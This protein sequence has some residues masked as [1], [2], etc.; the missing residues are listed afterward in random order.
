V[1][2]EQ[3]A[4]SSATAAK[5]TFA[6]GLMLGLVLVLQLFAASSS[7]HHWLH[8]DSNSSN[9]QCAITLLA[10]GQIDHAPTEVILAASAVFSLLS[11]H[12]EAVLVLTT[13]HP[14]TSGRSPP[15]FFA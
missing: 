4:R 15:S 11:F 10:R 5:K 3:P 2:T 14:I 12:A 7:L 13:D 8:S 1:I 6:A 9:H